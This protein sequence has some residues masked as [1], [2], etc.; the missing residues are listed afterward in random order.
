MA[1]AD[2]P[3]PSPVEGVLR[4]VLSKLL[5]AGEGKI[6]RRLRSIADAV[7]SLEDDIVRL[8]DAELRAETDVFRERLKDGET[9]DDILVEAFAVGREAAR[10]TAGCSLAR[11]TPT[12]SP[13][14]RPRTNSANCSTS[15]ASTDLLPVDPRPSD[16]ADAPKGCPGPAPCRRPA[17]RTAWSA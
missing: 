8:T 11:M 2:G 7:N 4:V 13:G 16:G 9:L 3:A 14:P 5:R 15:A 6:L 17:R 1:V 10:R 12:S